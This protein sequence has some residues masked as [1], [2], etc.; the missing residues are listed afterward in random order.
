MYR[1][2]LISVCILLAWKIEVV[3]QEKAGY[4][5]RGEIKGLSDGEKVVMKLFGAGWD[6]TNRDSSYVKNGRFHLTGH[7]PNGPR[8][9]WMT[10]SDMKHPGPCILFIDN[11]QS[12]TITGNSSDIDWSGNISPY[13]DIQGSSTHR[14]WL[15]LGSAVDLKEQLLHAIDKQLAK[16]KDSVGFDKKLVEGVMLVRD[17]MLELYNST[18]LKRIPI[19]SAIAFSLHYQFLNGDHSSY[20]T[21]AYNL[22]SSEQKE[23]FY[24][25]LLGK[26]ARLSIG[27]Q[28]PSFEL[29]DPNGSLLSLKDIASKGKVCL[30][31]F[32]AHN[33]YNIDRFQEE[34]VAMYKRYHQ[35]G[36][37][38]VGISADTN[39]NK[40]KGGIL[41][42]ELEWYQVS[43]LKG[44]N[45][46]IESVYHEYGG[47]EMPNTTNVLL[48]SRGRIIA[49]DVYGV[50]LQY[51]LNTILG[52]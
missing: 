41:G 12:I 1:H 16:V 38:I 51:L 37:E 9:Y 39:V 18:V 5:I 50:E 29:P 7:V 6:N 36:L 21:D 45:G 40:W 26:Y 11:N 33:S 34:L 28:F 2:L 31:H 44:R 14:D 35:K 25:K 43:D 27:Q 46:I 4:Q 20:I 10:F 30:V 15:L 42:G 13:L 52:E 47:N 19:N 8:M 49:W 3:A 24:G 48:D 17:K 22:L 23:S 32:W